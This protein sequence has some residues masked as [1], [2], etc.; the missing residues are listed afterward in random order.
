M[1][2]YLID[3]KHELITEVDVKD[4]YHKLELLNCRMLELYPSFHQWQ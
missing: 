3:T 4:Y 1:K 2:A